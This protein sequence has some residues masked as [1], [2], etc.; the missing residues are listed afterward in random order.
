MCAYCYAI[1]LRTDAEEIIG[2]KQNLP[3]WRGLLCVITQLL[4]ERC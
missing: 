3:T 1:F 2:K 4:Q